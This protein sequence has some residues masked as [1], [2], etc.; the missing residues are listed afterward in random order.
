MMEQECL[1]GLLRENYLK[2]EGRMNASGQTG[3][4]VQMFVFSCLNIKG[5]CIYICNF[6][7]RSGSFYISICIFA[8]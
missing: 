2:V 3:T 1:L 5:I 7:A 6:K 8:T 4:L